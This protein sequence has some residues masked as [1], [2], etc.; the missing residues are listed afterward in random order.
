MAARCCSVLRRADE[1]QFADAKSCGPGA[2]TLALSFRVMIPAATVAKEPVHRG[3]HD[4]S[5]KT[6]ARGMPGCLG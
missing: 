3:E 2:A 1:R 6:I 5:V 4:I